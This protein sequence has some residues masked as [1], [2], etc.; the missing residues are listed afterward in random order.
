MELQEEK[1]RKEIQAEKERLENEIELTADLCL[2][3]TNPWR[4]VPTTNSGK[5][6]LAMTEN[7]SRQR[8]Q[9]EIIG[10][11]KITR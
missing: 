10:M 9:E 4:D 5:V 3:G 2:V 7:S 11:R 1:R 8:H 6:P